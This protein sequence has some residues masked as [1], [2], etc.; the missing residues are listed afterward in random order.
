HQERERAEVLAQAAVRRVH[1]DRGARWLD[2]RRDAGRHR[3]RGPALPGARLRPPRLR[4]PHAI[5]RLD[6]AD[7]DARAR[8]AAQGEWRAHGGGSAMKTTTTTQTTH[9]EIQK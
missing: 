3:P 6:R 4:L 5:S 8:G 7:R 2:P 1:E 9:Y